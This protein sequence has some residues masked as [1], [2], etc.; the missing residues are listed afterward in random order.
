M[1]D[2]AHWILTR[3][4]ERYNN[5]K[6]ACQRYRHLGAMEALLIIV[7]KLNSDEAFDYKSVVTTKYTWYG[8]QKPFTRK[9]T[10]EEHIL[11]LTDEF[12]HPNVPPPSPT[13]P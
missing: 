2:S 6:G 4:Y 8:K 7:G 12:L 9:E 13:S 5:I 3:E 1:E 11:R 10:Y